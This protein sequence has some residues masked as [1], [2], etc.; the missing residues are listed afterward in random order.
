MAGK[1]SDLCREDGVG[2]VRYSSG[3]HNRGEHFISKV[4]RSKTCR[5]AIT[6]VLAIY[7]QQWGIRV[8]PLFR[9]LV[10]RGNLTRWMSCEIVAMWNS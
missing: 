4:H 8:K 5:L 7:W 6:V 10:S 3:L 1:E 2:K 9:C